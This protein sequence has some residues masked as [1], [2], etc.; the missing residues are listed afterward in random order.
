MPSTTIRDLDSKCVT[1]HLA[2]STEPVLVDFWAPWCGPCR[3]MAPRL[4]AVAERFDGQI[5]VC[6]VNVDQAKDIAAE[7]QIRGIPTLML[8]DKGKPIGQLVGL[9]TEQQL[10]DWIV[11][12]TL[13]R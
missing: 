13:P 3:A 7:F 6:K 11:K 5:N 12:S 9:Q 4:K 1:H 2:T 8:F 10:S